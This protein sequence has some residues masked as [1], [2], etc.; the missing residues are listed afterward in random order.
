MSGNKLFILL[1]FLNFLALGCIA[2]TDSSQILPDSILSKPP[3]QNFFQK[4]KQYTVALFLPFESGKIYIRDLLKGNFFIPDETQLAVE[5]YQGLLLALDSLK[6]LGLQLK[7]LAYDSGDS[8][9]LLS[10]LKND[11][12]KTADLIM[13]PVLNNRLQVVEKFSSENKIYL[14]SPYSA[15]VVSKEPNS[16]YLMANATLQSHCQKIESYLEKNYAGKKVFLIHRNRESDLELAGFFKNDRPSEAQKIQYMEFTDSTVNNYKNLKDSLS[17]L[18]KNIVIVA[19]SDEPFANSVI[20]Q[21]SHLSEDYEVEVYGMP[22]W[23]KCT[24]ISQA[25]LDKININIS[26][27]F[28]LDKDGKAAKF[29]KD[30]YVSK[31]NLSPTENAVRGYDQMMFFG[32]LMLGGMAADSDINKTATLIGDQFK[33]VPVISS[34]EDQPV[35]FYENKTVHILRYENGN[36][37]KLED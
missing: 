18:D 14:L 11:E 20:K 26:S 17:A 13:G 31:F 24:F 37:I 21:L 7:L 5:Y 34:N 36:W 1:F 19:S 25:A 35:W 15:M 16:F 28:W 2:Q 22:T 12:I 6:S 3:S 4:K 27:S 9:H 33:F 30:K 10:I 32:N 8:V 29:F 23:N